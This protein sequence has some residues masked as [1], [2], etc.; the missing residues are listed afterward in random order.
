MRPASR[1]WIVGL[2]VALV[3]LVAAGCV[4][5]FAPAEDP[6]IGVEQIDLRTVEGVFRQL[7]R[8]YQVQDTLL[9]GQVIAPDFTFSY[10]DYDA[11]GQTI[12]WG[13]DVELR[14]TQRLFANATALELVWN[15]YLALPDPD[16]PGAELE[17]RVIRSFTL[18]VTSATDLETA[19]G[20]A[21]L[22]LRRAAVTDPWRIVYWRDE[23]DF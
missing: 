1:R 4:N 9:Y 20:N 17:Q 21:D 13:R 5:P 8:A 6:T 2:L 7:S 10:R 15:G 11:G 19:S 16:L 18:R 3:T 14:T 23:S 12:T 22:L